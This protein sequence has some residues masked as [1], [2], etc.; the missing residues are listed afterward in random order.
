MADVVVMFKDSDLVPMVVNESHIDKI[1]N[2]ISG[3]VFWCRNEQ[4]AIEKG[5]DGEVLFIWGGSGEMPVRYCTESK[6]L[7]WINSFS[8]GVNPI[9]E[10]A[11]ADLPVKLTNAKG[12]HGKTMGLT[13]IGYMI[14]FLRHSQELQRRQENHIWSKRVNKPFRDAEGLTVTIVGAGSIGSEVAR[15]SKAIGMKV[16]GVKRTVTPLDN[17]DEVIP[18]TDLKKA[19]SLADFVVILTPLTDATRGLIGIHELRSMKPGAVLINIARGAVVK[20]DDLI[21]ALKNGI[22]AGAALDAVDPEPLNEDNPLWDMPNVIITP[23]CAADSVKY[24]DRAVEQFCENLK[25]FEQGDALLNEI[26]MANKY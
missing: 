20:T 16:I 7:K 11:I 4:E 2:C 8:A 24:I 19:L 14:S 25:R 12:I 18:N 15:L 3:N 5:Y 26:N 9:M 21:Y 6:K 1:R 22:I 17:Y 10:S 23:H 13:T